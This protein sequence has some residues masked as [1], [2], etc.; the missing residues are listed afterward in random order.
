MSRKLRYDRAARDERGTVNRDAGC[1]MRVSECGLGMRVSGCG[2]R[3]AGLRN[4]PIT[5]RAT[6]TAGGRSRKS[7][8]RKCCTDGGGLDDEAGQGDADA[9]G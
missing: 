2:L 8:G 6:R 4:T 7:G 1:G 3:N 5:L 9:E